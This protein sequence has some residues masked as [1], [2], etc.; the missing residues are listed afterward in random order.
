MGTKPDEYA[1][2]FEEAYVRAENRMIRQF[3]VKYCKEDGSI[4]WDA[5]I[6]FNSGD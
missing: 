1:K 3:T 4:D 5:L 2:E 6:R